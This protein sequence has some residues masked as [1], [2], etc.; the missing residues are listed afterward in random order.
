M[1]EVHAKGYRYG[2]EGEDEGDRGVGL[3][4]AGEGEGQEGGSEEALRFGERA[5]ESVECAEWVCELN[6]FT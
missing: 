6:P 2:G 4:H 1:G 5:S 3:G